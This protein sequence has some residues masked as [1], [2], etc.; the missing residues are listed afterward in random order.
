MEHSLNF[1]CPL[2]YIFYVVGGNWGELIQHRSLCSPAWVLAAAAVVGYPVPGGS[3]W[4]NRGK[5]KPRA[6]Q[7]LAG[8]KKPKKKTK[9][10]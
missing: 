7:Q 6:Q 3:G 2:L 5:V 10:Q 8:K 4:D 9:T 1:F